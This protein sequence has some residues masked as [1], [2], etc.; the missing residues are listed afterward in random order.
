MMVHAPVLVVIVPLLAAFLAFSLGWFRK[1]LCLPVTV[2]ALAVTF[3]AAV[4]VLCRVITTG[5]VTY[6]M[7]GWMPPFGIT[8]RLDHLNAFVLVV[9]TAVAL[10]H[11]IATGKIVFADFEDRI[12][13]FYTLYLLFI[14]GLTGIVATGDA[15]NLYV[16]LEIASLTGYALVGMGSGRAALAG[17]NYVLIGTIGA[18]FY[19]LGIGYLYLVTGSLN[20]VDMARLVPLVQQRHIVHLALVICLTGLMIK[21]AFFPLHVWLPDAYTHAPAA[22]VSLVAPL[23]TK[24]MVYAMIRLIL[25]VFTPDW[26]FARVIFADIMVWLATAAI[27]VPSFLA[28]SQQSLRKIFCYILIAEVAYM[29]GGLWLANRAGMIGAILH[30]G[31]DA[32]MTLGAFL[33]LEALTPARDKNSL[34]AFSGRFQT[35][36]LSMAVFVVC[37]LSFIGVPPTCG[38]FSKWFLISGAVAAGHYEFVVALLFSSLI[39]LVIFFRLIEQAFFEP[40][41]ADAIREAPLPMLM[42][43]VLIAT[44]LIALGIYTD[45]IVSGI[46]QH[47]IPLGFS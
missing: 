12:G 2:G 26:T 32:I 44:G 7:G 28:L 29:V 20:M 9:V 30:I 22:A 17:L 13:P 37:A 24:V 11:C 27:I 1:Q 36:P 8:Y 35:M 33:L 42:S 6:N 15:F 46:I 25:S 16:L 19:L 43:L 3:G 10:V 5:P 14:T 31:N 40:A 47:V 45:E 21:M 39:N 41:T 4:A 38:F 34:A 18:S 23:T